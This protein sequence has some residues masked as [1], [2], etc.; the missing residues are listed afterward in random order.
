MVLFWKERGEA[1]ASKALVS[2][3]LPWE[4]MRMVWV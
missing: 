4:V 1:E 2:Q 3:R